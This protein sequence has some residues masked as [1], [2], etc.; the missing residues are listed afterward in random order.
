MVLNI[1]FRTRSRLRDQQGDHIRLRSVRDAV[2]AARNS[3][4]SEREGLRLR[5]AEWYGRAVSIMDTSGEYGERS[6]EDES[7]ISSASRGA[8]SAEQR[9]RDIDRT[10]K[11]FDEILIKLDDAEQAVDK[12][13]GLGTAEQKGGS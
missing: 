12:A 3:A 4:M 5:M 13:D 9:M 10:I 2:V 1:R 11:V 6:P 8:A 7:E